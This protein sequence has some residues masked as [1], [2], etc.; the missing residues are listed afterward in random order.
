MFIIQWFTLIVLTSDYFLFDG[1]F[2]WSIYE[3]L[4]FYRNNLSLVHIENQNRKRHFGFKWHKEM[5]LSKWITY[6]KQYFMNKNYFMNKC[7]LYLWQWKKTIFDIM[8]VE[9]NHIF[10]SERSKIVCINTILYILI[11]MHLIN[12]FYY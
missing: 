11:N 1:I 8:K 9:Q 6:K 2:N 5:N 3:N 4:W 10:Y 12:F 7:E